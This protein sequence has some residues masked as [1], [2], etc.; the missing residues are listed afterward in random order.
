MLLIFVGFATV[1]VVIGLS[2]GLSLHLRWVLIILSFVVFLALVGKQVTGKN[3]N[4]NWQ[5][6]HWAGILIDSRYK[7]SLSRFQ[8]ILWTILALSAFSVI[9]LDRTIP[10]LQGKEMAL[11]PVLQ[12]EIGNQSKDEDANSSKQKAPYDA[13]NIKFP[14][15]LLIALGISTTSLAGASIIK[16]NKSETKTKVAIKQLDDQKKVVE[17]E[18]DEE[19]S[20]V[21]EATKELEQLGVTLNAQRIV[22]ANSP[23]YQKALLCI[24]LIETQQI[25]GAKKKLINAK[26]RLKRKNEELAEFENVQERAVGDI[27]RNEYIHEADWSDMFRGELVS[28][29][30]TVDT[31]KVQMFLITI[32]ILFSYGTL[33]WGLLGDTAGLRSPEVGLPTFTATLTGLLGI[34]HAGYLTIKQ[35]GQTG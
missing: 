23:E 10:V 24:V 27:D 2:G 3:E 14:D 16:A 35:T 4:G 18:R 9:A 11:K 28:N 32:V 22:P 1:I 19:Q 5:G 33:L 29:F 31:G 26:E 12:Q 20:T 25:P 8:I 30:Q 15:E 17:K 13:L 6:G 21:N 34:S 7:M